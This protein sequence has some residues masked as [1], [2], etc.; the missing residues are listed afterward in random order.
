[1]QY[2]ERVSLLR[3]DVSDRSSP[4]GAVWG[5]YTKAVT[6]PPLAKAGVVHHANVELD[7]FTYWQF[8]GRA[9]LKRR[10]QPDHTIVDFPHSVEPPLLTQRIDGLAGRWAAI[11]LGGILEGKGL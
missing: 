7:G 5:I 8:T 4:L 1:M 3:K 10:V 11:S 6:N 2:R 9:K